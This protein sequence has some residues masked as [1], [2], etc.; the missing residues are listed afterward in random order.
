MRSF[1]WMVRVCI[2]IEID[3]NAEHGGARRKATATA[4]RAATVTTTMATATGNIRKYSNFKTGHTISNQYSQKSI[5]VIFRWSDH[6]LFFVSDDVTANITYAE[7][8]LSKSPYA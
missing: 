7:H 3:Q 4:T 2:F 8:K 6:V 1:S 5:G